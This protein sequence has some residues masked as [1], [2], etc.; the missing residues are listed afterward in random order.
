MGNITS[1]D[2]SFK[3]FISEKKLQESIRQVAL[4][5]NNDYFLYCPI[6]NV[7]AVLF[8][9]S[10]IKHAENYSKYNLIGDRVFYFEAFQEKNIILNITTNSYFRKEGDS[11]STLSS[12]DLT[13]LIEYYKEHQEFAWGALQTSRIDIKLYR[14]Y[15]KRF[16]N[17]VNNRLSR[18]EKLNLTYAK[19]RWKYYQNLKLK[20]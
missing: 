10:L 2:K 14:K 18:L 1:K 8:K 5:I 4:K 12:K 9:R 15:I 11:V 17:R 20:Q 3:P 7:S 13:Y 19:L 6:L 16:F